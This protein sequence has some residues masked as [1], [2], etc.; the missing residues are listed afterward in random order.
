[1]N[2]YNNHVVLCNYLIKTDKEKENEIEGLNGMPSYGELVNMVRNLVDEVSILKKNVMYCYPKKGKTLE[3]LELNYRVDVDYYDWL[4]GIKV[5]MEWLVN[6]NYME[7]IVSIIDYNRIETMPVVYVKEGYIYKD[8]KWCD[9]DKKDIENLLCI[10]R[11][12]ILKID[13]NEDVLDEVIKIPIM[14]T[15]RNFSGLKKKIINV[16]LI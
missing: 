15:E 14:S 3:W 16:L 11:T 13:N 10:I 9:I 2:N 1:M 5:N 4:D 12:K 7:M 6:K 8:G